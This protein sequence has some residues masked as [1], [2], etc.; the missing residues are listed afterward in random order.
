[1]LGPPIN[2]CVATRMLLGFVVDDAGVDVRKKRLRQRR[3]VGNACGVHIQCEAFLP[4]RQDKTVS[5]VLTTWHRTHRQQTYSA[6][7]WAACK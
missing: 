6:S 3:G 2:D 7:H 5:L 4:D 1:M